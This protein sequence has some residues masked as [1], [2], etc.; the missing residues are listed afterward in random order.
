[1]NSRTPHGLASCLV[2][3]AYIRFY[4]GWKPSLPASVSRHGQMNRHYY[5]LVLRQRQDGSCSSSV[6]FATRQVSPR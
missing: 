1:M 2:M 3:G 5:L 4:K 6:V